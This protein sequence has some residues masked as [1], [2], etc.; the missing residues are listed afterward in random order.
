[1]PSLAPSFWGGGGACR[2]GPLW[3]R[4]VG[5]KWCRVL[6]KGALTPGPPVG[7]VEGGVWHKALVVGSVSPWRRLLASRP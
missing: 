5:P 1:M 6:F 2:A 4:G 7:S 3:G